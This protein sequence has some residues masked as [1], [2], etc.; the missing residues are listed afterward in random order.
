MTKPHIYRKGDEVV[1]VEPKW[2]K[3]VGYPIVWTDLIH[4]VRHHWATAAAW[5]KLGFDPQTQPDDLPIDFIRGIAREHVRRRRH[6]GNE[7]TIHYWP[8]SQDK[9]ESLLLLSDAEVFPAHGYVGHRTTVLG[10][11]VVKTGTRV[12]GGGYGEDWTDGYLNDEKTHILLR[13]YLGEIETVH[14][15]P[16]GEYA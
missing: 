15:R 14:V 6:G 2:V 11:R 1:I 5:M 8:L 10:K 16:V 4:E 9:N 12:P 3:R 7:R 13:T